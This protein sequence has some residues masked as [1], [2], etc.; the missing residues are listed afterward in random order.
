MEVS[1]AQ[2]RVA[3]ENGARPA[4]TWLGVGHLPAGSYGVQ[5]FTISAT[6]H[7]KLNMMAGS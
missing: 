2:G 4:G 1:D 7:T 3:L 5:T 6:N